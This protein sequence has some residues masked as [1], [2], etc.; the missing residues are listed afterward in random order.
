M[1]KDYQKGRE[2]TWHGFCSTTKSIEVLNNSMFCGS[3][4]KRTIFQISLT[5]GQVCDSPI[6]E[7]PGAGLTLAHLITGS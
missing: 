5:Q 6:S 3:S 4:G 7:L 2:F 1:Q